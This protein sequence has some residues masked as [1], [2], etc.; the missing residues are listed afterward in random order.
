MDT[1]MLTTRNATLEDLAAILQTQKAEQLDIVASAAT[2]RSKG[3]VLHVE[4]VGEPT[5]TESGVTPGVGTFRPTGVFDEGLADKLQIP[6][7]LLRRMR[8]RA[9]RPVRPEHQRAAARQ[10]RP[11]GRRRRRG[12]PPGRRPQVPAAPVPRRRRRGGRGP[13]VAVGLLQDDRQPG[14]P[15]RDPVRGQRGPRRRRAGRGREDRPDRPAHVR[16]PDRPAD[17]R[18]RP[19]AAG[20]LPQPVRRPCRRRPAPQR[21]PPRG[22]ARLLARGGRA[23]RHGLRPRHRAD[24]LRRDPD[25]QQRGRRR[26]VLHRA[27]A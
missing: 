10:E 23:L 18:A 16:R 12:D 6:V 9:A 11:E 7:A 24:R 8:E 15:H 20:R 13:R 5:I 3:G 17:R 14:H 1:A 25:L 4:G 2:L 26:R 19:G 27:P 22:R 21:R